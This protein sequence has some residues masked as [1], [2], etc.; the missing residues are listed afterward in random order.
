MDEEKKEK[1]QKEYIKELKKEMNLLEREKV[2][3]H[4][5]V[6]FLEEKL[7]VNNIQFEYP[8]KK[9]DPKKMS[10]ILAV[11]NILSSVTY[12]TPPAR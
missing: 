10:E 2:S 5:K 3:L 11:A 9:R 12:P 7:R 1:K 6:A 4:M 8:S